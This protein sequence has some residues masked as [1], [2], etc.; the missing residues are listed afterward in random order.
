[1]NH[2]EVII[3]GC[4]SGWSW[5]NSQPEKFQNSIKIWS[6]YCWKL[7]VQFDLTLNIFLILNGFIYSTGNILLHPPSLQPLFSS[8]ICDFP[9]TKNKLTAVIRMLVAYLTLK[10]LEI[11]YCH[12]PVTWRKVVEYVTLLY[13]WISCKGETSF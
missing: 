11:I 8:F 3:R 6:P 13:F 1:M 12:F 2:E 4:L 10:K 7:L 5:L 9:W